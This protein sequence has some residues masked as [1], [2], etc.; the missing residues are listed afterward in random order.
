MRRIVSAGKEKIM[1]NKNEVNSYK[2]EEEL[3]DD[4]DLVQMSSRRC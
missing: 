1:V 3:L 2:Y 4:V